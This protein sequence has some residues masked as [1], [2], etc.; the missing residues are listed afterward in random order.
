MTVLP[1][2]VQ[3]AHR[4]AEAVLHR[5]EIGVG[6]PLSEKIQ[7]LAGVQPLIL[8]SPFKALILSIEVV[9]KP[10]LTAAPETILN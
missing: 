8:A 5:Q 9:Q 2:E 7:V 10:I 6:L 1:M 3:A 4:Q